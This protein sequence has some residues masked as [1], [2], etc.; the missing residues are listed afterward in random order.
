MSSGEPSLS[1]TQTQEWVQSNASAPRVSEESI[2]AK[3]MDVEY[4]RPSVLN[5]HLTVCIITMRNGFSVTG[6]SSPAS[7]KNF[8]EQ[9]GERYAYENAFRQIW[10]LEGYLLKDHLHHSQQLLTANEEARNAQEEEPY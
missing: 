3:I 10:Q 6:V 5:P 4:H 9:V 1:M 7:P 2:K 8:N